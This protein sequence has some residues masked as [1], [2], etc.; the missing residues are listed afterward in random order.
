MRLLFRAFKLLR[1]KNMALIFVCL[2]IQNFALNFA[3][4]GAQKEENLSFSI[5]SA[6]QQSNARPCRY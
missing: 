3:L 2:F 5:T 1:Q 4:A 6:L